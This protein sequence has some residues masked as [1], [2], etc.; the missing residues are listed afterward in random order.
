MSIVGQLTKH[1]DTPCHLISFDR[2][3]LTAV[4]NWVAALEID[5]AALRRD[6]MS[7]TC[8]ER[9]CKWNKRGHVL[10]RKTWQ[11]CI[12]ESNFC[13]LQKRDQSGQWKGDVWIPLGVAVPCVEPVTCLPELIAVTRDSAYDFSRNKT[14]EAFQLCCVQC[15][16]KL[17]FNTIMLHKLRSVTLC[18]SCIFSFLRFSTWYGRLTWR[19]LS[20]LLHISS[21]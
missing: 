10:Q 18:S 8:K 12:S 7:G 6:H 2:Y 9:W 19:K 15:W 16:Q 5:T 1:F 13:S 14:S 11:E 17:N 20:Q 3:Y 21:R 4:A